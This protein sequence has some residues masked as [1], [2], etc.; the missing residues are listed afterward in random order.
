M[1]ECWVAVDLP[2]KVQL[3]ASA[4]KLAAASPSMLQYAT[5]TLVSD[6]ADDAGW[7]SLQT[8]CR[9]SMGPRLQSARLSFLSCAAMERLILDV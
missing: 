6:R 2:W 5:L 1:W 7:R 4:K 8:G 9:C 3:S